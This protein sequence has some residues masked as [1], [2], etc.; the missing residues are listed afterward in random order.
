[1]YNLYV[2]NEF[3][4]LKLTKLKSCFQWNVDR[5]NLIITDEVERFNDHYYF[6]RNRKNLKKYAEEVKK[7][8]INYLETKLKEVENIKI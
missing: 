4:I 6:C 8:W 5:G 7:S 1:M 2:D 3:Y